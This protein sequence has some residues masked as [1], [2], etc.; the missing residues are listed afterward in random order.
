MNSLSKIQIDGRQNP[1]RL[2]VSP[3]PGGKRPGDWIGLRV[4]TLVKIAGKPPGSTAQVFQGSH[5]GSGL[6]I[7]FEDG[8][9]AGGITNKHIERL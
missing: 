9:T 4:T 7:R 6:G 3:P 1:R 8:T 5:G 2:K